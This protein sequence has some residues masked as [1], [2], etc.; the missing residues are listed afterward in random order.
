SEDRGAESTLGNL[1]ADALKD[2]VGDSQLAPADFG[3]TNP[4]GL[5]TDLKCDD[6]YN[7]EK[8]CEVTAAELN[9]VLPFANDHGVVTMKGADVI[10]LFEEQWQP[11]GA[12]RPFLHLGISKELDVVYDS[13]AEAGKRVKSVKVNGEEIDPNRDYRVATLSFLAAGG[14]NFSSFAK[15]TF[16]QSGLT[17]FETWTKYFNDNSPVAPD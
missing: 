9:A 12:S 1:V 14:D 3:I 17:D 8:R 11:A 15:G 7:T 2:G 6:I 16:E 10:G 5:R 4:G 13:S